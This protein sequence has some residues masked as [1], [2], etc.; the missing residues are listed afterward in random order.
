MS[1]HLDLD[2]D[3]VGSSSLI[4]PGTKS[5]APTYL[6]ESG[7]KFLL[8]KRLDYRASTATR[9]AFDSSPIL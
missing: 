9:S 2:R 7:V 4:F 8:S 6:Q 5:S 1:V 3:C